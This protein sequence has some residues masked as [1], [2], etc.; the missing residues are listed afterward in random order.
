MSLHLPYSRQY[1]HR[2]KEN[3]PSCERLDYRRRHFGNDDASA[4]AN[5]LHQNH[6]LQ[7]LCFQD[8]ELGDEGFAKIITALRN[9]DSVTVL[10]FE[11]NHITD[12]A[13][14]SLLDLL[15]NHNYSIMSVN[16]LRNPTISPSTLDS[17]QAACIFNQQPY[18]LKIALVEMGRNSIQTLNLSEP[19]VSVK[20]LYTE[21]SCSLLADA[22]KFTH[23]LT[24]LDVSNNNVGD[25]R[26]KLLAEALS[27][28]TSLT[29]LKLCDNSISSTGVSCLA[30]SLLSNTILL[31]LDLENNIISD[32]GA[33]FLINALRH[34]NV[35]SQLN[36][37]LNNVSVGQWNLLAHSLLLNAQ[38]MD[39]KKVLPDL[40]ANS[41]SIIRLV[42]GSS[43]QTSLQLN[44]MSCRVLYNALRTNTTVTYLD[45][46]HNNIGD[47]GA[48][49]LS[50]LLKLND[51]IVSLIL[52]D[53]HIG[54][55]GALFLMEAMKVNFSILC[56]EVL[57]NHLSE[58]VQAQLAISVALNT[59]PRSFKTLA[60]HLSEN[61]P[62][63]TLVDFGEGSGNPCTSRTIQLLSTLLA[64]NSFITE[65]NL[66]HTPL[67]G[68][69]GVTS[70]VKMIS[71]NGCSSLRSL[72]L[73]ENNIGDSSVPLFAQ[74]LKVNTGLRDLILRTNQI[75]SSSS[76]DFVTVLS[77]HNH[78]LATLDL[79]GNDI[80]LADL[81][82]I[83]IL[84]RLNAQPPQLKQYVLE[85][86]SNCSRLTEL[87]L[88]VSEAHGQSTYR[89]AKR[90]NDSCV[91]LVCEALKRN[92]VLQ[93]LNLSANNLTDCGAQSIAEMLL[94]NNTLTALRLDYNNLTDVGFQHIIKSL[95]KN[96]S[97]LMVSSE[98]NPIHPETRQQLNDAVHN[99]NDG[100]DLSYDRIQFQEFSSEFERDVLLDRKILSDA[101]RSTEDSLAMFRTEEH[102]PSSGV[103]EQPPSL[104]IADAPTSQPHQP[105]SQGFI[106]RLQQLGV[107]Y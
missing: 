6:H 106:M 12:A 72:N 10:D 4:L 2:V 54:D 9:N 5:A 104:R 8:G 52:N 92:T 107:A 16:L 105:Y 76:Y 71:S 33:Q 48:Q 77:F 97:V 43:S 55:P 45:F 53:N 39:L 23:S 94:V 87:N 75:T 59:E 90:Y 91:Q 80:S 81:R 63:Y 88:C 62:S 98:N 51:T 50:A 49:H 67:I 21:L 37:K 95:Y 20:K 69:E 57:Q 56:L 82:D 31:T 74:M 28:N 79:T 46:S 102:P 25:E 93:T 22:L 96:T 17:I 70:L 15:L 103:T 66:A 85:I 13:A 101:L 84:T 1:I 32:E 29:E 83:D 64:Q 3:D 73:S 30:Q 68:V 40:Q 19:P 34:N 26:T 35:L 41:V 14:T 42:L 65:I 60:P 38:P 24:F 18:P 89:F 27:V 86:Y 36:L 47:E 100:V 78:T 7:E 44:D 11:G 99:K 61:D 58:H